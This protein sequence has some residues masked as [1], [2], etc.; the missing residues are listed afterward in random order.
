MGHPTTLDGCFYATLAWQVF[1]AEFFGKA[2]HAVRPLWKIIDLG[3]GT[4][5]WN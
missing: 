1:E 5:G 3:Y 2:A 4:M